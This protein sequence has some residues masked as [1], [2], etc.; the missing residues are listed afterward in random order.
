MRLP[1]FHV[2]RQACSWA[3]KDLVVQHL[4]SIIQKNFRY[5]K[6]YRKFDVSY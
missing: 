1:D 2:W 5:F 3:Y 6:E 4:V